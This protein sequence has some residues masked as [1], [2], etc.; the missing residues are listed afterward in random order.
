MQVKLVTVVEGNQ[1]AELGHYI[2]E[3]N[4]NICVKCEGAADHSAVTR[5][6]K[7]FHSCCKNVD[8]QS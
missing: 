4:E 7:K 2:S 5:S 8:N 1:K 6:F 3:A